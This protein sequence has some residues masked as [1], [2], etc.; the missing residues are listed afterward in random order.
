MIFTAGKVVRVTPQGAYIQMSEAAPCS[1]CQAPCGLG[2]F[3]KLLPA[4][5]IMFVGLRHLEDGQNVE[6]QIAE[7]FLLNLVLKSYAWPLVA[8][9][10]FGSL[11]H[12]V[13]GFMTLNYDLI[14]A[15]FAFG[16]MLLF[17]HWARQSQT[18]RFNAAATEGENQTDLNIRVI[19]MNA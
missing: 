9:I 19:P 17:I 6:V 3:R 4:T 2:V 1:G 13:A 12:L 16:G 5:S 18:V 8:F 11:G 15:L 7:S 14:S 10:G